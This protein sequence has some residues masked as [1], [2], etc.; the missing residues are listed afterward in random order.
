MQQQQKFIQK[1]VKKI[2]AIKL[3][4]RTV[5]I[6]ISVLP[7]LALFF[8]VMFRSGPLAPVSV[9]VAVVE[10]KSIQPAVFGVGTVEASQ[11]FKI[12]PN[13]PGRVKRVLVDVGER[14]RKGQLLAVMERPD[15]DIL[16]PNDP[17]QDYVKSALKQAEQD[18]E[19]RLK[20]AKAT[21]DNLQNKTDA[22]EEDIATAKSELQE[23][24]RE[25]K[26]LRSGG[27]NV[28]QV[29]ANQK[30]TA[31]ISGIVVARNAEPGTAV[32]LGQ[33]V[34]D[35][36][37]PQSVRIGARFDQTGSAGLMQGLKAKIS[38]RSQNESIAGR[39][40]RIEPLA[41][42][43]T[44]EIMAKVVFDKQPQPLPSLGEMAEIRIS[45]SPLP[46]APT[47]LNASLVRHEGSL[48]VWRL[49]TN[50]RI[51]FVP[52]K[53]GATDLDGWVE[54]REG[55]NVGDRIVVHSHAPLSEKS[56]LRIVKAIK[57]T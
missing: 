40:L 24:Q 30:L 25:I 21:L 42:A 52:V 41:D 35:I 26:R 43:V 51:A 37:D 44:E 2:S 36:V 34:I 3:N 22:N 45:L 12:G 56:R 19:E 54:V 20:R 15:L 11:L 6:L 13:Q 5:V 9:T 4:R 31:P 49:D 1:F 14:V 17:E 38:L 47:I 57:G 23:A 32:Q 53:V 48:G 7:I 8:F 55:L 28:L 16:T 50:N 10:S 27:N 39:V 29:S 33:S 46:E 18:A